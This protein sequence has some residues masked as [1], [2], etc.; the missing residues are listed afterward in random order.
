MRNSSPSRR[1]VSNPSVETTAHHMADAI[2]FLMR[3]ATEAGLQNIAVRLGGVRDSLL[4]SDYS[5]TV[6]TRLAEN[7]GSRGNPIVED[8]SK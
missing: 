7:K 6:E 2:G 1:E 8:D 5:G 4:A 3:V